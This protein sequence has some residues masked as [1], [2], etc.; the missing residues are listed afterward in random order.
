MV[1]LD[2][3]IVKFQALCGSELG[4]EISKEDAYESGVKLLQL[5]SAIYKPMTEEEYDLTQKHREETILLLQKRITD[6]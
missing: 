5:M 3:D 6:K 4:I 2:T 1:L